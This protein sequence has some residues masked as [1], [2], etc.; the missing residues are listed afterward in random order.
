MIFCNVQNT[1][2][3]SKNKHGTADANLPPHAAPD[4]RDQSS[5]SAKSGGMLVFAAIWH[6][7]NTVS[8]LPSMAKARR[9]HCKEHLKD[10]V[11]P[12]RERCEQLEAQLE[13]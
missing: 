2:K 7:L 5:F 13:A 8:K 6:R 3:L 10:L 1:A 12:Q 9:K 11:K 4:H